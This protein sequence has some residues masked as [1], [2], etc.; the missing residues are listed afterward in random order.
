MTAPRALWLSLALM[1]AGRAL[2]RLWSAPRIGA[3]GLAPVAP[4]A[5][6]R[7]RPSM[8]RKVRL[9]DAALAPAAPAPAPRA[10]QA[11]ARRCT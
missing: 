7:A 11:F 6:A 8:V 10:R 1:L 5:V 9:V 2:I 3:G 4:E